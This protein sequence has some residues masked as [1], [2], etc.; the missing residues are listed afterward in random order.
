[1]K[2]PARGPKKAPL[3]AD[4]RARRRA[5]SMNA[6]NQWPEVLTMR[7]AAAAQML[8]IALSTLFKL[9]R[10]GEI[11]AVRPSPNMTLIPVESLRAFVARHR[12]TPSPELSAAE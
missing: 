7:P 4:E 1:M 3:S 11:E 6:A 9:I 8:G 10:A 12:A 2:S 5:Q